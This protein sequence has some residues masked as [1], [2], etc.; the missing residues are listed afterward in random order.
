MRAI[1][2]FFMLVVSVA[3]W[4]TVPA[5][6]ASLQVRP[7]L[8]DV[9]APGAA[10]TITLRSLG[11]APINAQ[12]RVYR[13]TQQ[14]GKD[15]LVPTNDVVASPPFATLA[16]DT[17]YTVRIVRVIKQPTVAEES[18]RLVIDEV[19][20]ASN[21]S[22]I[23]VSFVMRY[24]IPVFFGTNRANES[25]LQWTFRQKA[26]VA[27]LEAINSGT[28]RIRLS[29]LTLTSQTGHKLSYGKGLVGYVLD[30]SSASWRVRGRLKG[31]TPGSTVTITAQ[32]DNGPV[33]A[34]AMV[35]PAQ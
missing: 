31:A 21:S 8:I 27:S 17:D 32:G 1:A 18:Y 29:S 15:R 23:N 5:S 22:G 19:P 3:V 7:V 26:G 34:R 13:W 30:H 6:A 33:Q 9:A 35:L 11:E 16:P 25:N 24:S 12:I 4:A 2:C 20:S 28:C 10:S 14:G